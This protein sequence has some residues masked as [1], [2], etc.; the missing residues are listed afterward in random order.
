MQRRLTTGASNA[1]RVDP[2]LLPREAMTE[3]MGGVGREGP[4]RHP[5]KSTIPHSRRDW[6]SSRHI[7]GLILIL[8]L[9]QHLDRHD[10]LRRCL[11]SL[12]ARFL[13]STTTLC[14]LESG[15]RNARELHVTAHPYVNSSHFIAHGSEPLTVEL[16]PV[17]FS[18]VQLLLPQ[19][20]FGE[21]RVQ[22]VR[23]G[24]AQ[25][26]FFRR[27]ARLRIF[28]EHWTWTTRSE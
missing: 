8:V 14:R 18:F 6:E 24:K 11:L 20:V 9:F 5:V 25:T 23:S 1:K 12:V 26:V 16:T 22:S 3:R 4:W 15:M 19:A 27:T 17:V 7:L 2:S 10:H 13:V 28:D 21:M